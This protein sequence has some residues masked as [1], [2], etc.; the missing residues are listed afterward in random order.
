MRY[1]IMM[2]VRILCFILM[3][4]IQPYGWY[5][6]VLGAAAVFLPYIAVVIANV[7][8]DV[9]PPPMENPERM[10]PAAP[11]EA[12]HEAPGVIRVEESRAP[13]I[14]PAPA[15]RPDDRPDPDDRA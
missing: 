5:T 15:P 3:V 2:G 13:G 6:W 4:F 9:A 11:S 8:S 1:L 7:D 14:A 10:L 12:R